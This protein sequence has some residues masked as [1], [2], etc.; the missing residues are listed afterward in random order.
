[1]G[2]L[3]ARQLT[4]ILTRCPAAQS[5][6][7]ARNLS[8]AMLEGGINTVLRVACFLGEVGWESD[9]LSRWEEGLNYSAAQ[10]MGAWPSRFTSIDHAKQ[11]E[12]QPEKIANYVY[13]N[14]HGNGDEASGD[15]WRYRAR[16][17]I[18]NTFKDTY[19]EIGAALSVDL[20]S[21]PERMGEPD[22]GFKAAVLF[23]NVTAGKRLSAK[24]VA[25]GVKPGCN[26][27]TYADA[28]DYK[29]LTYAINGDCTDGLPTKY[30][31]RH[32]LIMHALGVLGRDTV[33][34]NYTQ[35]VSI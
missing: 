20:V 9:H 11:Y 6:L 32:A 18:G 23:W 31:D 10:L 25:Y 19:R 24:A 29:A 27:N 5:E 34:L 26:L 13:A 35:G 15:G 8:T 33:F 28:M 7:Y 21:H 22:I 16:G 4:T 30:L 2:L 3:T 17:P 12:R 14:R 1:M